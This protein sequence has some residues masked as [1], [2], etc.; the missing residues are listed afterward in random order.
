[1]PGA[2][3]G[4][5]DGGRKSDDSGQRSENTTRGWKSL[6]GDDSDE[7][8]RDEFPSGTYDCLRQG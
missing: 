4:V 1:M 2:F 5:G 6:T 8:L 3:G 7:S